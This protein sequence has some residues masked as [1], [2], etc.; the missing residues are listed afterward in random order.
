[1]PIKTWR[2]VESKIILKV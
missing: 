1:V 2:E